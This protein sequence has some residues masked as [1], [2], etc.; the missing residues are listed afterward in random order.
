MIFKTIKLEPNGF[1]LVDLSPRQQQH[2]HQYLEALYTAANSMVANP[3][4]SKYFCRE[5]IVSADR[6]AAAGNIEYGFCQALHGEESAV[7]AWRAIVG[8]GNPEPVTLGIFSPEFTVARPSN[9]CGNCRDIM[10]DEFGSAELE[11][12]RG[13]P[14]GEVAVV[15][16]LAYYLFDDYDRLVARGELSSA[17]K[18]HGELR[19]ARKALWDTF[20]GGR[21]IENDAYSPKNVNLLRRYYVRID[22]ASGQYLGAHDVMSDYHPLYALRDAVR[23]VRRENDITT[24]LTAIYVICC[25]DGTLP[26]DVMY[27]D[28]QH[29]LELNLQT[30][31][32]DGRESDPPIYLGTM[33][34]GDLTGMW[35]TSAK[36]WLPF[37]FTARNF[38]DLQEMTNYFSRGL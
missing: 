33:A 2:E 30:E 37:P 19:N 5:G 20:Y 26:P 10:R 1:R 18:A 21:A 14:D 28:R 23:Q 15:V 27:K 34:E 32:V 35:R 25:G 17:S 22:T 9:P 11:I 36:K 31:L 8:Q 7:A 6:K 13:R 24:G 4:Y 16:P 12:V 3:F 29:L 38:M